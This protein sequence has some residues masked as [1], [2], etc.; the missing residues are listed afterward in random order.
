MLA[1]ERVG[2]PLNKRLI[3][4]IVDNDAS[5]IE[6]SNSADEQASLS[7]LLEFTNTPAYSPISGTDEER[8]PGSLGVAIDCEVKTSGEGVSKKLLYQPLPYGDVY[9]N[10]H[11]GM[12]RMKQTARQTGKGI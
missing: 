12:A 6:G 5:H 3:L 10:R 7:P 1:F 8:Y 2:A 9:F 4:Y 11:P